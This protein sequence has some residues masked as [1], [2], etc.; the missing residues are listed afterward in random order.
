METEAV[1]VK[2]KRD[3]EEGVGQRSTA[4]SAVGAMVRSRGRAFG[5]GGTN[6][7]LRFLAGRNSAATAGAASPRTLGH[8]GNA[9]DAPGAV[10]GIRTA[11]LQ[12][13]TPTRRARAK[14]CRG[15]AAR[16]ANP[17]GLRLWLLARRAQPL[18]GAPLGSPDAESRFLVV[19]V[20]PEIPVEDLIH[21]L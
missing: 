14:L 9:S 4:R 11:P 15:I 20:D 16:R 5:R 8:T 21:G 18:R 17:R 12:T 3:P 1:G 19:V 13:D 7:A 6:P 10:V 2:V